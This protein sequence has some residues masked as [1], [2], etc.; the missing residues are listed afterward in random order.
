[1]QTAQVFSLFN[2][3]LHVFL[4][5]WVAI[6]LIAQWQRKITKELRGGPTARDTDTLQQDDD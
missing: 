4:V 2:L 6:W 1:M 3:L 5:V